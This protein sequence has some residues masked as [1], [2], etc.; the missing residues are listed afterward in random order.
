MAYLH[1]HG[2]LYDGTRCGWQQD[3]FWEKDSRRDYNSD[4][5]SPFRS[6]I[7]EDLRQNLFKD[8]VYLDPH[9]F[10]EH[11]DLPT[12]V[13]IKGDL[14]CRGKDYVAHDL[15]HRAKRIQNMLVPTWEE[16]KKVKDTITCPKCG[17][18]DWDID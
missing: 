14:Y 9:Y 1:C 16:W 2:K 5:Y 13:D 10:E 8:R 15:M 11:A 3:D 12:M 7:I 6:D 18:T 4:P 17:G